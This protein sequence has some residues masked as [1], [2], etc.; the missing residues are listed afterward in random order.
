MRMRSKVDT[1]TH[2]LPFILD[3]H[4]VPKYSVGSRIDPKARPEPVMPLVLPAL[5]QGASWILD[6][7]SQKK[8][9]IFSPLKEAGGKA[10]AKVS[11]SASKKAT[12][13]F[14]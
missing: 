14:S 11:L 5:A 13:P 10:K 7:Q 9:R 1:R 3:L 12:R 2:L 8:G 4:Q 6:S